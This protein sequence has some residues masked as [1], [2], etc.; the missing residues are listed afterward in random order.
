MKNNDKTT[1][2]LDIAE[3]MVRQYGYNGFSFRKIAEEAKVKSASVHY[4][5]PTKASLGTALAKRYTKRFLEALGDPASFASARDAVSQ[6]IELYRKALIDDGLMCLCGMLGAEIKALPDDVQSE[7]RL[8]FTENIQ[9][10]ED[11]LVKFDDFASEEYRYQTA[12]K[13]IATLEGAAIISQTLED[14]ECFKAATI[15][16][17]DI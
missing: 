7:V 3:K 15:N 8:F 12:T 6:Y 13:I 2:I 5:F 11:A 4:H 9:W 1:E 10:L 14:E 16:L 17:L